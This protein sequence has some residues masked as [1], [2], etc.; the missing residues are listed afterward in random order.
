MIEIKVISANSLPHGLQTPINTHNEVK[1]PPQ[2]VP[3]V[4]QRRVAT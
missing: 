3:Q 2:C 4:I 1:I